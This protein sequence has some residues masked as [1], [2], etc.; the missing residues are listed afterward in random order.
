MEIALSGITIFKQQGYKGTS[1]IF[2][3]I[4]FASRKELNQFSE[5]C[6]LA[7]INPKGASA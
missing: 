7:L 1:S 5:F 3:E 4:N 6:S 2:R